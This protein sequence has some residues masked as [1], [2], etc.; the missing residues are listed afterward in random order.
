MSG[1][2][3]NSRALATQRPHDGFGNGGVLALTRR[4]ESQQQVGQG[5]ARLGGVHRP[6]AQQG[7]HLARQP[8]QRRI[9][10]QSRRAHP[11]VHR[12]GGLFGVKIVVQ[13]HQ[14]LARSLLAFLQET[15]AQR[16][17][18]GGG[19][20]FALRHH[21][22]RRICR[23]ATAAKQ[24]ADPLAQRAGVD[25]L[26]DVAVAARL[27]RLLVVA[28]HGESS[29]RDH[30]DVARRFILLDQAGHLQPVHSGQL[31]VRQD[32]PRMVAAQQFEG[33]LGAGRRLH[34]VALI[35]QQ[36]S[37][38]FEVYRCVVDDE[39]RLASHGQSQCSVVCGS[40]QAR[41]TG[42]PPPYNPAVAWRR[43]RC[44]APTRSVPTRCPLEPPLC[45]A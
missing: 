41:P 14:H 35:D 43:I 32:Q 44:P 36:D 37:S 19:N 45:D 40:I 20:R 9:A 25:R 26:S 3:H 42:T 30:R 10:Q 7:L 12:A 28:F 17:H 31:D 13:I 21:R 1:Q 15:V 33:F 4:A 38:E 39:N 8:C 11:L 18:F 23:F 5:F 24:L 6:V 2:A 29:Q 27:H 16:L 22:R 34:Q